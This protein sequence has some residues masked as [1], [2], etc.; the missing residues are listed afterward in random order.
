MTV[1]YEDMIAWCQEMDQRVRETPEWVPAPVNGQ[2][3]GTRPG[4]LF[5]ARTAWPDLLAKDGWTFIFARNGLGYWW[6][7]GKTQGSCSATTGIRSESN[8]D[9]LFVFSS[10]A[11]VEPWR[12]YTKFQY[13]AY[14]RHEG[15]F[16]EAASELAELG[17]CD[18]EEISFRSS[19][20]Q[21]NRFGDSVPTPE[22][23]NENRI[24]GAPRRAFTVKYA[25]ELRSVDPDLSFI[26]EGYLRVHGITLFSALWKAGKT[27]LLAH[28]LKALESDGFFCG[29]RVR[30]GRVLYVTEEHES[31]WAE[32]RD[33]LGLKDHIRF[34]L[35]P[36]AQ[37]PTM[38]QWVAFLKA[39]QTYLREEPAELVVFDTI[40]NL[41][42][43]KDENDAARVQEAIMP[44]RAVADNL[45]FL[46]VHH[47]R[48][49]DGTEATGSRGSGAL[50][51]FADTLLELRRYNAADRNDR[52][53]V[54]TAYARQKTTDEMVVE[55]HPEQTT[56]D[57]EVLPPCY[58]ALGDRQKVSLD[59]IT[60]T[61]ALVLPVTEP[62]VNHDQILDAWPE[63]EPK[64]GR[65]D[66]L[67]CLKKG[68]EEGLWRRSGRGVRGSCY[69]YWRAPDASP[70]DSV[71]DS[72]P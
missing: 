64:P 40:V 65:S 35:Q 60:A 51:A 12:S 20:G 15:R 46:L 45:A 41:W 71:P 27:T 21:A 49:S 34:V 24:E 44:L 22:S 37:K 8:K 53:R 9:L 10:N 66:L 17:Y 72:L 16:P 3:T 5:N 2:E 18:R 28:L 30:K 38:D 33:L 36:F 62:G 50:P 67:S 54:L 13:Y 59:S 70:A 31:V 32:R 57:G 25:S 58:V 4:D 63:G 7:P 14:T 19:N 55:L 1:T 42:P 56:D 39:L 61:L 26:W 47:L 48:K 6:R 11:P 43:V 52:R 29:L 69:L 68:T 23:R